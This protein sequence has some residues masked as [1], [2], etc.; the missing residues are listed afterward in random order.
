MKIL[1]W[2]SFALLGIVLLVV[3]ALF[4]LTT[5]PGENLVRG[6]AEDQLSSLLDQQVEIGDFETN[7]LSRLQLDDVAVYRTENGDTTSLLFLDHALVRYDPFALLQQ[8]LVL[9]EV[10]LDS[11]NASLIKDAAGN[12]NL[13]FLNTEPGE[14]D[15]SRPDTAGGGFTFELGRIEINNSYLSYLDK[16]EPRTYATLKGLDLTARQEGEE[17]RFDFDLAADSGAVEVQKIETAIRELALSGVGGPEGGRLANLSAR[18]PGLELSGQGSVDL[19]GDG[20]LDGRVRLQGNPE[21]ALEELR[22]FVP[23]DL[24]PVEGRLDLT[25]RL[26]GALNNPRVEAELT[27]PELR[28]AGTEI[29]RGLVRG[30]WQG[31]QV[32]LDSLDLVAFGGRLAAEGALA[33]DSLM[34]F[35][36]HAALNGIDAPQVQRF[37]TAGEV[38]YQGQVSGRVE[39][40]G[41][42]TALLQ[43]DARANLRLHDLRYSGRP[44]APMQ[45]RLNA[46][47]GDFA[48]NL[49]QENFSLQAWARLEDERLQGRYDVEI[50][51]L[52]P[53][54]VLAAGMTDLTGQVD[55]HGE[56]GGTLSDPRVTTSLRA[57]D[58]KYGRIPLDSLQA[59]AVYAGGEVFVDTLHFVGTIGPPLAFIKDYFGH[60]AY[61][62][63]ARGPL[64][65]LDAGLA[66]NGREITIAGYTIDEGLVRARMAGGRVILENVAARHREAVVRIM[67]NVDLDT[68]AGDLEMGF[69]DGA[70]PDLPLIGDLIN[71][72]PPS[73]DYADL[74]F[75]GL[76]AGRFN[77]PLG[78]QRLTASLSGEQLQLTTLSTLAP[79]TLPAVQGT[80]DFTL[81]VHGTTD[82][83]E[84]QLTFRLGDPTFEQ[85]NADSVGGQILLAERTVTLDYLE[86]FEQDFYSWATGTVGMVPQE[87]GGYGFGPE[88]PTRGEAYGDNLNLDLAEPFLGEGMTVDG[89]ASYEL[90]W[91]G[92]L[93]YP[94]AHGSLLLRDGLMR[95]GPDVPPFQNLDL[96]ASISDSLLAVD[97]FQG[98]VGDVPFVLTARTVVRQPNDFDLE[99]N[100]A[101]SDSGQVLVEGTVAPE[102]LQ[103]DAEVNRLNLAL[104]QPFV[105]AVQDLGGSLNAVMDAGGTLENPQLQGRINL[106]ELTV[107]LRGFDNPFTGGVVKVDFQGEQVQLDSLFL[108]QGEK[109]T[110]FANGSL[111]YGEGTLSDV[112]LRAWMNNL[113]MQR[114]DVIRLSVQEAA[115]S[116]REQGEYLVLEG[117]INLGETRL[118]VD[119][120][121][122]DLLPFTRSVERPAGAPSPLIQRTR[123]NLRF[124]ESDRVW[125]DNNVATLRAN[126]AVGVLGSPGRINL[127]GRVAVEE[128]YVMFLDRRFEVTQGTVDFVE[129][130]RINPIVDIRAQ[131]TVII[132][133]AQEPVTY[134]ITLSLEGPLDD[135]ITELTSD[136]PLDRPDIVSLLTIGATREQLAGTGA[137]GQQLGVQEVLLQRVETLSGHLLGQQIAGRLGL[138]QVTLE[139]NIFD[140]GGTGDP[141][142]AVTEQLNSRLSVTYTTN[143]GRFN[144]NGLELNYLL[145]KN[146][147][148]EGQ[149]YQTGEAGL[150]LKWEVRFR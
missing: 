98:E 57:E 44:A 31:E 125:L 63:W 4:F 94:H 137:D 8:T 23:A 149:A 49:D 100:L 116:Y 110:V 19:E 42:L 121:P 60:L 6:I 75:G 93:G 82:D 45:L 111:A 128:G 117:D 25:A 150:D 27:F 11:L 102:N 113:E 29:Q 138:D 47:G 59:R 95:L 107:K 96:R 136:P 132:R 135:L 37:F 109:G 20:A 10:V 72:G 139:G 21:P 28:L 65:E 33:L 58:V 99:L 89:R 1:K 74:D 131:S 80:L 15:T 18:L 12:Y 83:P 26:D 66:V 77:L 53:L 97:Y 123:L 40:S 79:D 115:L 30:S 55:L 85:F 43:S 119:F 143:V 86:I 87:G 88:S 70:T 46:E 51:S 112:N 122:T 134:E 73:F 54:L 140:V 67:G 78:G 56:L 120:D 126:V 105:P 108:R 64:E 127:T 133:L 91:H 90:S 81:A 92:D 62:G 101:V 14:P 7:L 106:R 3:L 68:G 118:L 41:R 148:L 141:T 22:A 36:A 144:E 84:G 38:P 35:R 147:Y 61:Q 142:L 145:I 32:V 2:F 24:Y 76:I 104:A 52:Q 50:D 9:E 48:L 39:A 34:E 71:F 114:E 129:V 17:F 69:W 16:A 13:A 130:N 146:L 124:R 103:L 5:G